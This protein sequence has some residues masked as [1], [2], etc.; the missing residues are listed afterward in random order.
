MVEDRTRLISVV[1]LGAT[2]GSATNLKM[3][4]T[5]EE[6]RKVKNI[7]KEM[8]FNKNGVNG[9]GIGDGYIQIMLEKK[10]KQVFPTKIE[11]VPIQVIVVGKIRSLKSK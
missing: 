2:P 7:V 9:I 10:S 5:I 11:G 6:L 8:Y 3:K 1:H 4:P